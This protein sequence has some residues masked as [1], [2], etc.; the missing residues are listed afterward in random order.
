M[1]RF[2]RA[3]K[4]L[5]PRLVLVAELPALGEV[6][7][8]ADLLLDLADGGG[9]VVRAAAGFRRGMLPGGET[10]Q[11][12]DE[13]WDQSQ[14]RYAF[15]GMKLGHGQILAAK[16]RQNGRKNALSHRESPENACADPAQPVG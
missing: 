14:S 7:Q 4:K 5:Q 13:R 12:A 10:A 3:A 1:T 9:R 15:K 8:L 16:N 11:Q 6:L 2:Q